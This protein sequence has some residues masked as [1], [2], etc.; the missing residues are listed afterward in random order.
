M[1]VALNSETGKGRLVIDYTGEAA[2]GAQGE[3]LNPEGCDLL[4]IESYFYLI[5]P[6]TA[7]ATLNVGFG[8]TG[9]DASDLHGA[10][11]LNGGAKTSWMG[12]HPAVTQDGALTAGEW[13]A[14][15]YLTFTTA[16]QSALPCTGKLYI[17][18]IRLD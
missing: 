3:I 6:A 18:Y 11:P 13:D 10:L 4:V 16:D 12:L 7:A 5:T 9:A 1:T 15:D 2:V 14:A 8:A 17:E